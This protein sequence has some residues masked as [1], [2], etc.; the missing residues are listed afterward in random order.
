[1]WVRAAVVWQNVMV[2]DDP[3]EGSPKFSAGLALSGIV[4]SQGWLCVEGEREGE[5]Q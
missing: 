4:I 3:V 1:M 5:E 2:V